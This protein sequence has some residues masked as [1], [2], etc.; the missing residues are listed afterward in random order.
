VLTRNFGVH[1]RLSP[2]HKGASPS[3]T[4]RDTTSR[5]FLLRQCKREEI[6]KQ[7]PDGSQG[8]SEQNVCRKHAIFLGMHLANNCRSLLGMTLVSLSLYM[9]AL[10]RFFYSVLVLLSW[11]ISVNSSSSVNSPE[12]TLGNNSTAGYQMCSIKP[13][14]RLGLKKKRKLSFIFAIF[15]M[16]EEFLIDR[17]GIRPH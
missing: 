9:C 4:V 3:P 13:C 14:L 6:R 11:Y 12:N 7:R 17:E 16:I 5:R 8:A 1:E 2:G 10:Y 15:A